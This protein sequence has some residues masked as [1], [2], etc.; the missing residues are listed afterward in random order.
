MKLEPHIIDIIVQ[1]ISWFGLVALIPIAMNWLTLSSFFWITAT[2]YLIANMRSRLILP[3]HEPFYGGLK[4]K[5]IRLLLNVCL[6]ARQM[7]QHDDNFHYHHHIVRQKREPIWLTIT[8]L[9]G[10]LETI[11]YFTILLP[12]LGSYQIVFLM[13][14]LLLS[15]QVY[16]FYSDHSSDTEHSESVKP[17]NTAPKQLI[18]L[19]ALMISAMLITH[20]SMLFI[21]N[22]CLVTIFCH[23]LLQPHEQ[24]VEKPEGQNPELNYLN[25]N[26]ILKALQKSIYVGSTISSTFFIT[27]FLLACLTP[28][29]LEILFFSHQPIVL[30]L[31]C[32]TT[33]L[34]GVVGFTFYQELPNLKQNSYHV[35]SHISKPPQVNHDYGYV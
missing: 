16:R 13:V 15:T 3:N 34:S 10:I 24:Q 7:A 9:S 23:F 26:H 2:A 12:V 17:K 35:V 22:S 29:S 1:T 21:L 27:N 19:L 20:A 11:H 8:F 32:T 31:A 18:F 25:P 28:Y 14:S 33:V 4:E 5:M 30:F 6:P